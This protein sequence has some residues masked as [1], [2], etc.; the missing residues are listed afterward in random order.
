M[1]IKNCELTIFLCDME[2]SNMRTR[3]YKQHCLRDEL[4]IALKQVIKCTPSK[5]VITIIIMFYIHF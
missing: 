2:L 1:S 3:S 4:S 5:K